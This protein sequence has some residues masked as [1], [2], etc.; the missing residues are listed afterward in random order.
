MVDF[1]KFV[2]DE[3][4]V[5]VKN[6]KG[7]FDSLDRQGSHIDLRDVQKEALQAI[8][9]RRQER[10][11][12]LKIS[13]GAGKTTVGLLYLQSYMEEL[14][15]PV[16]Y[17]C[18]TIQLAEQVNEE[19]K[20]IGI[21]AFIYPGR[22]TFPAAEGSLAEA[23]I[24]CTYEKLFNAKTTFDRP[25][26]KLRPCAIVLDDA[27]AGIERIRSSFTLK[28]PNGEIAGKIVK[29]LSDRCEK[30]QPGLWASILDQNP[31]PL[32]SMEIP[33]WIWRPVVDNVR[34]V[35][36]K[37][38]EDIELMFVW[39][40]LRDIL[41]LC[42]CVVSGSGLEIVPDIL[43]VQMNKAFFEAKHR[44]FMSATL[45]D[46]STLVREIGCDL[47][48]AKNPILPNSDR[49]LG[50]RMV[51]APSLI[52]KSLDRSWVMKLCQAYSKSVK[53]V[54]LAS[55]EASARQWE[56][57][58]AKVVMTEG[59]S[60]SVKELKNNSSKS[61]FTVF[62]QRYDG[63]DLPDQ[64][65]RILVIDGLPYGEGVIDKH[66]SSLVS[67]VGGVRN[68]LVYRIE[69]GMGRAVRSHVDYAAVILCGDELAH[70]VS[71]R[72][73]QGLMTQDTRLQLQ[74]ALELV[75]LA[76]SE[77]PQETQD[78]KSFSKVAVDMLDK[79]LKRDKGWKEYY[80]EKVRMVKTLPKPN[81]EDSRLKLSNAEREA[82]RLA[83]SNKCFEAVDLLRGTI[84]EVGLKDEKEIGWYLQK[85]AGYMFEANPAEGL[86]IQQ[87]AHEKNLTTFCPPGVALKPPLP[88]KLD[89]Q[90]I[91]L[92]WLNEFED[93]NGAIAA[94]QNFRAKLSYEMDH[95]VIEQNLKELA[96]LLGAIGSRPEKEFGEGPDDLWVWPKIGLVIE[97][98]NENEKTV[99]K[100]DAGQL[101]IS[102]QWFDQNYPLLKPGIPVVAA[103]TN[104]ADKKSGYPKNTRFL[105]AEKMV[106]LMN[107]LEKFY[108]QLV[109]LE[110]LFR[111][112]QKIHELQTQFGLLPENFVGQ[113]TEKMAEQK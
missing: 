12:V 73:V 100:K 66:D 64:A 77:V 56:P 103:K 83:L 51:L 79:F 94:I 30:Y 44:L 113:Y 88:S 101:L 57:F 78:V 19:A 10:D 17:L 42:R 7:L 97:A 87:H 63:V 80:D 3:K 36:S 53:V 48:A 60:E 41:T 24:I 84:N 105:T 110:P 82:F 31:D 28:F 76:K 43:P 40:F 69:Q 33:Y 90:T 59:I 9:S 99:H 14:R 25:D 75:R 27:H 32:V 72:D 34:K 52:H 70:F 6:L 35:L 20:K 67:N 2:K 45:A 4:T 16:V 98:K 93:P 86:K 61:G 54:V 89:C 68:R 85:V 11:L 95:E 39:P 58:G 37:H 106:D 108:Q 65:C 1:K 62:V 111:T 112:P 49:G 29:V 13:T 71:K 26:V 18:P 21:P 74:L 8:T 107:D 104:V 81:S 47:S 102:L 46:D 91:I 50:E 96:P 15:E 92:K 38:A 55:S 23:I 109:R 22:E 5:D